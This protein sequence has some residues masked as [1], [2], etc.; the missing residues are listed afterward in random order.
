M[1]DWMTEAAEVIVDSYGD[2]GVSPTEPTVED[3]RRLIANRCP[4]P[5]PRC[6][7]CSYW[8]RQSDREGICDVNEEYLSIQISTKD[9]S[10]YLITRQ[11][12]GC[13]LWKERKTW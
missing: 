9:D 1:K 12:F 13:T 11:E 7:S 10:S 8:E 6:E 4:P 2:W 5:M 3:V